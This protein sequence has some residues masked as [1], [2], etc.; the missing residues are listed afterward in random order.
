MIY[1]DEKTLLK[2]GMYENAGNYVKCFK[3][4][5]YD[6]QNIITKENISFQV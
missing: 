5:R 4:E 3:H 2:Y 6:K 1:L